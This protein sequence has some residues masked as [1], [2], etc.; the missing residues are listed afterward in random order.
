MTLRVLAGS[1]T[2]ETSRDR[3][4]LINCGIWKLVIDQEDLGTIELYHRFVSSKE[5][6]QE[7]ARVPIRD[8]P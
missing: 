8:Y 5:R 6:K 7:R 3:G 2:L 4:V 1:Q